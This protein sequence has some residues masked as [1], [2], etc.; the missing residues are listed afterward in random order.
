[1]MQFLMSRLQASAISWSSFSACRN[2]R[3]LPIETA[4]VK[5][6]TCSM[7]L[8]TFSMDMR[9]T[10]SSITRKMKMVLSIWPNAFRACG[11]VRRTTSGLAGNYQAA[12][13]R[14]PDALF[15]ADR[16]RHFGHESCPGGQNGEV[17]SQRRQNPGL[18][19]RP[20]AKGPG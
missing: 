1:M 9:N 5:A 10:G 12:Y 3:G 13:V 17:F 14:D 20:S 2:S 4:R 19:Y 15:L 18:R 16:E 8:S 6:W 11:G 7:A